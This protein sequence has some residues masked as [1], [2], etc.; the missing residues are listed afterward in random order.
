MDVQNKSF[1]MPERGTGISYDIQ[2]R[3]KDHSCRT[4]ERFHLS[5]GQDCSKSVLLK[6]S[7]VGFWENSL[8]NS[9]SN[10]EAEYTEM[11]VLF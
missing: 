10:E 5:W 4:K 11:Q 8:L 1:L 7:F 9:S 2:K 6:L 3:M